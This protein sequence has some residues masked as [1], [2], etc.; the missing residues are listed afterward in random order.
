[1]ELKDILI[2]QSK[3]P[4][5][6]QNPFK[7][8]VKT[9]LENKSD[10]DFNH[11]FH[12]FFTQENLYFISPQREDWQNAV[13]FIGQIQEQPCIFTFTDI[14]IAFD[15]CMNNNGFRWENDQAFVMH[16]PMNECIPMFKEL[17]TRGVFGIRINEGSSGFFVPMSHLEG[18][19]EHLNSTPKE[20]Q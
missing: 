11:L 14:S 3:L 15:F 1:M 9:A 7:V 10:E 18:I 17:A 6:K 20:E 13:P 2:D 5:R 12:T 8:L 4:A 19:L 16:L